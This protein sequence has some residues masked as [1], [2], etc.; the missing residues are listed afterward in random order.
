MSNGNFEVVYELVVANTGTVELANLTLVE[1]LNTQFGPALI[2]AGNVTLTG[3]PSDP[4]SSIVLDSSWDGSGTI[5]IIDQASLTYLAVGDSFTVQFTVEVDPDASGTS[6][7]L[8]NQ[9]VVGGAAVDANGNPITDPNG[10]PIRVEDDSDSGT[11]PN[12]SNPNDQGDQGTSDDPTPLFIADLGIAK[13]IVGTPVLTDLGNFVVTYQAV[14]ENTGTVDLASLSLV[15]DLTTQFGSAFVNA[16]NLSIT[17]GTT[18]AN[19]DIAVNA[20]GWNGNSTSELLDPANANILVVGDSFTVQFEVEIDPRAV[21]NTLENQIDGSGDAIDRNGNLILDGSGQPLM[22]FDESDSGVDPGSTNPNEDGDSG[23]PD[24]P[25]PFDPPEVPAGRISGTVFLDGNDDGIQDPNE[26]GIAGVEITLTGTD[27]FGN[28]V[29]VTVLTDANGRYVFDGLNAGDYT[30]TQAQPAGFDDGIDNSPFTVSNDQFTD[31]QL[32]FGQSLDDNTFAELPG[33]FV[34]SDDPSLTSGN[35]PRFQLLG[36]LVS[37]PISNL[38]G[39]FVGAPGPIYSGIPINA[40]A[41]PLSLDSGR[42]VTGGYATNGDGELAM[43]G[44]G[45]CDCECPVDPCGNPV[46]AIPVDQVIEGD[47][48]ECGPV[49]FESLPPV[50]ENLMHE[51][52]IN[53]EFSE[54]SKMES[55]EPTDQ[56]VIEDSDPNSE[57]DTDVAKSNSSFL[58][59]FSKWLES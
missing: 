24:D 18:D 42:A 51:G 54:S 17:S 56:S 10:N 5:E 33:D 49:M 15:E 36:P 41:D 8:D 50:Q 46:P 25:T 21:T 12:S 9:V 38:I 20:A 47:C 44:E 37:N 52:M 14:I 43:D 59:R 32:G 58:K 19:S 57:T 40:N 7:P 3:T 39:S 53:G 31:I 35:P 23:T 30:V 29:N 6:Q 34:T 1:D 28:P 4:A 2:S 22:A 55:E 48:G 27:V 16:G 26:G 13:S 11:D 45:E